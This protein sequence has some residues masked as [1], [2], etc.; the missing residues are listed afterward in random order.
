MIF[1]SQSSQLYTH[2]WKISIEA[3]YQY[4]RFLYNVNVKN[5]FSG[6]LVFRNPAFFVRVC[7]TPSL[8]QA[9][10]LSVAVSILPRGVF[11]PKTCTF[12]AFSF[13]VICTILKRHPGKLYFFTNT[14]ATTPSFTSQRLPFTR[15]LKRLRFYSTFA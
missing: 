10:L 12:F 6:I 8:R 4:C 14:A 9:V 1:F 2:L 7:T 11:A 5:R 15:H 3:S 13:N